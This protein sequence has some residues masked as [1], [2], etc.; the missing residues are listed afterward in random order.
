M[1]W[2]LVDRSQNERG[3]DFCRAAV[4]NPYTIFLQ[5]YYQFSGVLFKMLARHGQRH[6]LNRLL[7]GALSRSLF[8]N[9]TI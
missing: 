2:G 7:K 3:I 8:M 1:F 5:E 6:L 9:I 4:S